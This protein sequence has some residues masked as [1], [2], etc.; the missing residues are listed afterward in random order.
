MNSLFPF[1]KWP[2][3]TSAPPTTTK[4]PSEDESLRHSASRMSIA[5]YDSELSSNTISS[6]SRHTSYRSSASSFT[7]CDTSASQSKVSLVN[8]ET[9]GLKDK[10]AMLTA[11]VEKLK[12]ELNNRNRLSKAA[13]SEETDEASSTS[14]SNACCEKLRMELALVKTNEV[15]ARQEIEQLKHALHTA[16]AS[17]QQQPV[18]APVEPAKGWS[19]W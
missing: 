2:A 3:A 13:V 11:E 9:Q 6:T 15:L 1:F 4:T 14:S 5:S 7:S 18:P 10:V 12:F 16:N 19:I 8:N 17:R